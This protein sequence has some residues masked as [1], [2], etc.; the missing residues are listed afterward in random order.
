LNASENRLLFRKAVREDLAEIVRLFSAATRHMDALGIPQ[1]DECYP[2][3]DDISGDFTR[4]ELYVGL[5]NGSIACSVTLSPRCE[6]EYA[7]GRWQ[8]PTLKFSVIHR[9]C[10]HPVFQNRH[11]ATQT[12]CFTEDILRGDGIQVVRLDAFSLN[13]YALLL[14]ERLGY[15]K[16]GEVN[17][18]KGLFYLYEK[19]L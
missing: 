10:V 3:R 15:R 5:L 7:Y 12:M 14:Y 16:V 19:R 8:Y 17:F 6:P 2:T 4:G 18:R 11:V 13:P 9:L 1:W